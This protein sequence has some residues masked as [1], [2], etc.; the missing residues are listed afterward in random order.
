MARRIEV[1]PVVL[2]L[3]VIHAVGTT[4]NLLQIALHIFNIGGGI[5]HFA[6]AHL[7]AYGIV[8]QTTVEVGRPQ[9]TSSQ[10]VTAIDKVTNVGET[11]GADV[12]F[13]MSE[14]I[15]ITC[16]SEGVEDTSVA[17]INDAVTGYEP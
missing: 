1:V 11:V 17:Q 16:A 5:E 12:G 9:D 15:G 4:E 2:I 6:V 7:G 14:D 3:I 8:A 10:V 13:G